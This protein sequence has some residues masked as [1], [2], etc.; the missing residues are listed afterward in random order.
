MVAALKLYFDPAAT[1]RLRT[2]WM[3][4]VTL[5]MRIPHTK[6]SAALKL[7]MDVLPVEATITGA[8]VADHARGQF[9]KLG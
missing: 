2:L 9:T 8:A 6:L 3:P 5:S 4:H 1:R 7:C